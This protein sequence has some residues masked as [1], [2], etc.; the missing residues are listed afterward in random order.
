MGYLTMKVAKQT[1][2]NDRV[3]PILCVKKRLTVRGCFKSPLGRILIPLL[4][5]NL[6]DGMGLWSIPI[7]KSSAL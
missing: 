1:I 7:R 2:V 5:G 4:F 6:N 3:A